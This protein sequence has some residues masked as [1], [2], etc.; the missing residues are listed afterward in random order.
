MVRLWILFF[1]FGIQHEH[2][3]FVRQKLLFESLIKSYTPPWIDYQSINNNQFNVLP[4]DIILMFLIM[5]TYI[6]TIVS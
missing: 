5:C 3:F 6:G 2:S 4:I 1:S